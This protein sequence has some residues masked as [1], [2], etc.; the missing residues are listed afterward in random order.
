MFIRMI[1]RSLGLAL[2][3]TIAFTARAADFD[4][5]AGEVE[6]QVEKNWVDARW[7]KTDVG[8][9]LSATIATPG[10]ATYKGIAIKVGEHNEATVCF[11]TDLLRMSAAWTGDFVKISPARYG[12]GG[13]LGIGSP[14]LFT[15]PAAPGW[16]KDGNFA[17]PRAHPYGP[18]PRDWA[19]WRGLYLSG[20]RVVLQYTVGDVEVRESPWAETRDG[21][22]TVTRTLEI[23]P[24]RSPL[25]LVVCG[26][27]DGVVGVIGDLGRPSDAVIKTEKEL[28]CLVIPSHESLLRLKVYIS[29]GP[30]SLDA[31]TATPEDLA[32]LMKGGPAHWGEP[33]ATRGQIGKPNG[34]F[35]VDTLTMPYENPWHA[36][37]FSGDLDFFPNGDAAVGTVHGDVW[38]V[39][40]I[41]DKLE[42][43][44]W[45][46]IAT[47]LFQPLGL[48]IIDGK[49]YVLGRDQITILEDLNGD[50]E[51]DH[52][53]NFNNDAEVDAGGH[54]Y[55][56][57][58]ETD[59]AGNFYSL[60]C[61]SGTAHGGSLLRI[62]AD[63][64]KLEVIATGFRNPNGLGV[65]PDDTVTVADQEGN[66][67]PSTRLDLIHPGG[68]YGYMPMH[69]RAETPKIYDAP[70][71]WMPKSAD[72]SAASQ[73]WVP[74]D[75]WGPLAGQMLHLSYGHS[76]LLLVVRDPNLPQGGVV[77]LPVRFI[78]GA[79]RGRFNPQDGH[80]Y[81][82]GL[83]GWQTAAL[84]DGC[85]QRVR[86]LTEKLHVPVA[87]AAHANGLRVTFS[88]SLDRATAED[89]GSYD[90]TR[91]NYRWAESYG[92]KDWSVAEPQKEGR[93]TVTITSA[94]VAPDGRSVF[95]TIPELR[96]A[97]QMQLRYNVNTAAGQ[98]VT[99]EIDH[100]INQLAP[101]LETP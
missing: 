16:A 73:V 2:V 48:K 46:R 63:G 49:V 26:K 92:S 41:D 62:S 11:D 17:D 27:G 94:K 7:Q 15:T 86:C 29:K 9:F 95:L 23:G 81:V 19:K 50:G 22:T 18:L 57:C 88:E 6:K 79:M 31:T 12:I 56:T 90:A 72:N 61:A 64:A 8:Q 91:W 77:P 69:H 36:L 38:R 47:G 45:Q 70:L 32:P 30:L 60:R 93:D 66:W 67:V 39:R 13:P 4:A 74:A 99:G 59:R 33:L 14:V 80:L 34:A 98:T 68:F 76:S 87:I 52:Y 85:F 5:P 96:P 35:A 44:T 42:H 43:L 75:K 65:G 53:I 55:A 71:C 83:R 28:L 40:G 82:T 97:M 24:S 20:S 58:L 51:T 37:L 100:T 3:I 84:R 1:I 101:A 89:P 78:S 10:T 21:K 25:T 54:G